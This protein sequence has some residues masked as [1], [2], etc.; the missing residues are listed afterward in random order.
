M[1]FV[2]SLKK[3]K[4]TIIIYETTSGKEMKVLQKEYSVLIPKFVLKYNSL[5]ISPEISLWG[6]T[7]GKVKL[8]TLKKITSLAIND[9]Y[10]ILK[11]TFYIGLVDFLSTSI[12]SKYFDKHLIEVWKRIGPNCTISI[13]NIE[14]VDKNGNRYFYQ[15]H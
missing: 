3:G 7:N 1:F 4:T 8:D 9:N 14:F 12:K 2:D 6:F 11:A 10:K 15:K 13:E 5:T